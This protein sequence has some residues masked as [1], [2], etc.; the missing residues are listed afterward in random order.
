MACELLA[1]LQV[2]AFTGSAR[3]RE[4]KRLRLWI[5]AVAGRLVRG[6]RRRRLRL[7]ACWPWVT[8][9]IAAVR[10]L[11]ALALCQPAQ[12]V[13][14][15]RKEAAGARGTPP[16]RPGGRATRRGRTRNATGSRVTGH[17]AK[18]TKDRG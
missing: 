18:I 5:F 9:I 4:P 1:W 15:I 16:I 13:P 11:N 7:A 3:Q 14:A 6:G 12:T 10:R 8:K 2:L 17:P